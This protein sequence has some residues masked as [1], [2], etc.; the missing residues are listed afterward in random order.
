MTDFTH[1]DV[2]GLGYH[3]YESLANDQRPLWAAEILRLSMDV[4]HADLPELCHVVEL[5]RDSRRWGDGHRAFGA[6]RALTQT[7]QRRV[8][9]DS[10]LQLLLQIAETAAKVIYNASGLP[11]PFDSDAGWLMA[12][13]VAALVQSAVDPEFHRRVFAR[14][15]G[16]LSS[17]TLAQLTGKDREAFREASSTPAPNSSTPQTPSSQHGRRSSSAVQLHFVDTNPRVVVA[18]RRYFSPFPEV[19]ISHDDLLRVAVNVAVSPAN[20]EGFMDGGIDRAYAAFFGP[21]LSRLV[22]DTTLRRPEGFLPV[23]AAAVI[24][25]GHP[26]IRYLLLAPTMHNPEHVPST[27][28]YRALRAALRLSAS[29]PELDGAWFCPGL[30]TQVGGVDPEDA[31]KEMAEAYHDWKNAG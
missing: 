15:A 3:A 27:N 6:V 11:A 23:G 7:N 13:R 5:G 4:L 26:V 20:S 25:T 17:E 14:L 16:H 1:S 2:M 12:S 30:T 9:I 21:K 29:H 28:A 18:L 24:A 8:P 31:A 22:R 19:S 10:Q